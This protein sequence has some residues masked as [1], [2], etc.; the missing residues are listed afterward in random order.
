MSRID[1]LCIC[2]EQGCQVCLPLS[3][4]QSLHSVQEQWPLLS[5]TLS[6]DGWFC[7]PQDVS[8]VASVLTT[9]CFC[10]SKAASFL[11]LGTP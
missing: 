9:D 11:L 8:N 7:P 2:L 4:L 5:R 6:V 3:A 10:P 1:E